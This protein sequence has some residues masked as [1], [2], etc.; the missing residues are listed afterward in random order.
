MQKINP[1]FDQ[2]IRSIP[3]LVGKFVVE[4]PFL[5]YIGMHPLAM[6]FDQMSL[7]R[8]RIVFD[9]EKYCAQSKTH[10]GDVL[11]K[12]GRCGIVHTTNRT[13]LYVIGGRI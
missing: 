1:T 12:C 6:D 4:N 9:E 11:Y 7:C 10:Y 5:H 2:D 3:S 8:G 13:N